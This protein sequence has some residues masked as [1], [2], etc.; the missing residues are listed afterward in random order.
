MYLA[1]TP[2]YSA[3]WWENIVNLI[4]PKFSLI[5]SA[6]YA[7]SIVVLA[8]ITIFLGIYVFVPGFADVVDMTFISRLLV[9]ENL[10]QDMA[11]GESNG[12]LFV[13][14]VVLKHILLMLL[15]I[16]TKQIVSIWVF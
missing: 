7:G 2:R 11:K 15:I 14:Y 4:L 3:S 8:L 9:N 12:K 10:K 6:L 16:I 1:W 13:K 5:V